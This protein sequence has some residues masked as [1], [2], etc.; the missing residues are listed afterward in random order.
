MNEVI[1]DHQLSDMFSSTRGVKNYINFIVAALRPASFRLA[2]ESALEFHKTQ[3]EDNKQ[4]FV[5]ELFDTVDRY[6][7]DLFREKHVMDHKPSRI[8]PSSDRDGKKKLRAAREVMITPS[9]SRI[10]M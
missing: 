7:T 10:R 3:L 8:I 6:E 2:M 5:Q 9:L 4:L 1:E